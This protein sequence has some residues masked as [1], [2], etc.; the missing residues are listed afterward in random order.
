MYNNNPTS[1]DSIKKY[2]TLCKNEVRNPRNDGWVQ[3]GYLAEIEEIF[4]EAE[5]A[6]LECR[7]NE[8]ITRK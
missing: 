7:K 6:L 5:K 8:Y 4:N 2:I 3:S 1:L